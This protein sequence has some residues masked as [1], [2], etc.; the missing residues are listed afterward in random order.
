M[1]TIEIKYQ[2]YEIKKW[3]EKIQ[4]EDLKYETKYYTYEFQHY[5]TISSFRESIYTGKMNIDEAG[6]DHSN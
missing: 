3:E 6:I 2:I 5:E 1:R 4:R